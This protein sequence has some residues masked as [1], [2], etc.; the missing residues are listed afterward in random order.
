MG[1]KVGF[2]IDENP[3]WGPPPL[4]EPYLYDGILTIYFYSPNYVTLLVI[5]MST[6]LISHSLQKVQPVRLN[7]YLLEDEGI[8]Y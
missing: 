6:N 8:I 7:G 1:E 4:E 3:I 5:F 2:L